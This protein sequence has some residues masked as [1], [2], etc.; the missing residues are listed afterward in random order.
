MVYGRGVL[1]L[2]ILIENMRR[3]GYE[4]QVGQPKVIIREMNGEKCEPIEFLSINVPEEFT[5]KIIDIVTSR[6]GEIEGVCTRNNRAY[7]EFS[8][9]SRGIIGLRNAVLTATE[10]EAV[11][12][13]RFKGFE[14]WKGDITHRRNG[15]LIAMETGE[16]ITYSLDKLQDRGTFF[17]APGQNVYAGQIIGENSR[18]T[19]LVVNVI[20]TKKLTNIRA[21]GSDEKAI[22]SPPRIFSLEEA[23]EYIAADEYVEVTPNA[24]RMRKIILDHLKRKRENKTE[25]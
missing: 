20:H 3:E 6:K 17:I 12:S 10:G 21:A 5:G 8:I 18:S 14:T 22:L 25:E 11:M 15:V 13:H 16:A 4:F 9:P 1:H 24:I 19:D 23:L 7:L 2:S